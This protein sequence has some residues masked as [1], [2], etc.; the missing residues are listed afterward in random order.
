MSLDQGHW[1][2]GPNSS[3]D[4]KKI[5]PGSTNNSPGDRKK[6]EEA[7]VPLHVQLLE[8]QGRLWA[9]HR[10]SLLVIIQGI[11]AAGFC[12]RLNG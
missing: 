6:T 11:D 10:R 4:L 9:E 3:V 1:R 5:Y 12:D 8:L 7:T 2:V